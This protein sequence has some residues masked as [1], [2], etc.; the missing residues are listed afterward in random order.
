MDG[1]HV[2]CHIFQVKINQYD[3]IQPP[4]IHCNNFKSKREWNIPK[5]LIQ[6]FLNSHMPEGKFYFDPYLLLVD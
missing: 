5:L 1:N 3:V 4:K 6:L 2:L